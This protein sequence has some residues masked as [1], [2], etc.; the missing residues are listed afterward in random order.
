MTLSQ[1]RLVIDANV[2]VS[3]VL[4]AQGKARQAFDLAIATG[5]VLMSN[6]TFA[7]LSEVLLRPK[8]DRYS[9]RAKRETFLDELLG[10]VE[11]VEIVE[12]IDECRDPKD[13]KYLELAVSG[14]ADLILTGDEDLLVLHPFRQIPIVRIQ[15][16]LAS[17]E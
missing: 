17:I 12:Q 7:E 6:D 8:F 1:Q 11:F 14:K 10:L 2:I 5:I 9:N 3:S 13:N 4:S 15:T 16:F